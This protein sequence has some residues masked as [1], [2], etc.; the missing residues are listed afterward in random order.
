VQRVVDV[1]IKRGLLETVESIIQ[2]TP[3]GLEF[4]SEIGIKPFRPRAG[5]GANSHAVKKKSV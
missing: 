1:L 4:L 2:L 3:V 5:R